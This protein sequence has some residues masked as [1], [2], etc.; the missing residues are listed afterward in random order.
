MR[1]NLTVFR[2]EYIQTREE[3]LF[4]LSEFKVHSLKNEEKFSKQRVESI[5]KVV[6]IMIYR[7]ET[8][9]LPELNNWWYYEYY[10]N[11]FELN[12][13]LSYCKNIEYDENGYITSMEP[14]ESYILMKVSADLLTLKEFALKYGVKEETVI[15][16]LNKGNIRAVKKINNEWYFSELA[17][18]PKRKYEPVSYSWDK[19]DYEI[20]D[21]FDYIVGYK[22]IYIYQIGKNKYKI[23]LGAPG[24]ENRK[25][26]IISDEERSKLELKLLSISDVMVE[27]SFTS[28][29]FVPPK[30][31]NTYVK[32][33]YNFSVKD[34]YSDDKL[35]YGEVII[36]SGPLKGR[37]GYYDDDDDSNAIVYLGHPLMVD[38]YLYIK[39]KFLSNVI[40]TIKIIENIQ[41]L[42]QKNR[43]KCFPKDKIGYLQELY[44]CTNM[45]NERYL[46]AMNKV[47][48]DKNSQIFISYSR[49]DETFAKGLAT[50][51]IHEGYTVF[52]DQWSIDVGENIMLR[53][54]EGISKS[55]ALIMLISRN[56]LNSTF[57]KEE[58]TSFYMKFV[59]AK[60][61]MIYPIIL[62][63]INPPDIL[64][65]RKYV[66]ISSKNGYDYIDCLRDL[67]KAMRKHL[68]N[69][70]F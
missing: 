67:L 47:P 5:I 69:H 6:D 48:E 55:N 70:D 54:S 27:D 26:I 22:W 50:D 10:F 9:E 45:L 60:N 32:N 24:E 31:D 43:E 38:N 62:D 35:Y 11:L 68:N 52:L 46:E 36:T 25:A 3:L 34:E 39:H 66:R 64:A 51:L 29:M 30:D 20:Y 59:Q 56:Y 28:I 41:F 44:Y 16:W 33:L 14:G 53:I 18:K 21:E 57:C 42:N 40:P 13:Y 17:D 65:A 15:K 7:L 19:I 12:L 4:S 58:W 49:E 8:S 2:S 61:N 1:R 63:D 37:I 23:I